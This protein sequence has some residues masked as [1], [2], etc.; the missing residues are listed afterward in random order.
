MAAGPEN[1][2]P[3][4]IVVPSGYEDPSGLVPRPAYYVE[5]TPIPDRVLVDPKTAPE[6]VDELIEAKVQ[7]LFQAIYD[8][9]DS[10]IAASYGL[11][12]ARIDADEARLM[13]FIDLVDEY[14][15]L[16]NS[17]ARKVKEYERQA[18]R[19]RK[20]RRR[21]K[22][23]PVVGSSGESEETPRQKAIRLR[24][25]HARRVEEARQIQNLI[26]DRAILDLFSVTDN[27]S[28]SGI[29]IVLHQLDQSIE[30]LMKAMVG[31]QDVR[32]EHLK[33]R[34]PVDYFFTS[35]ARRL[36][37]VGED[38]IVLFQRYSYKSSPE[39]VREAADCEVLATTLEYALKGDTISEDRETRRHLRAIG[40]AYFTFLGRRA[41]YLSKGG[42]EDTYPLLTLMYDQIIAA[43]YRGNPE[44]SR[45][46]TDHLNRYFRSLATAKVVG[47]EVKALSDRIKNQYFDLIT[48]GIVD[49][50]DTFSPEDLDDSRREVEIRAVEVPDELFSY[51]ESE[52]MTIVYG[53]LSRY[54]FGRLSSRD[55]LAMRQCKP[56]P[57]LVAAML[58]LELGVASKRD[59][60][61][62]MLV[63]NVKAQAVRT[64]GAGQIK[65]YAL[66]GDIAEFAQKNIEN[67]S[68]ADLAEFGY[69]NVEDESWGEETARR[70]AAFYDE[71]KTLGDSELTTA[72]FLI[73]GSRVLQERLDPR[74]RVQAENAYLAAEILDNQEWFV[75]P[76]GDRFRSVGDKEMADYLIDAMTFRMDSSYPREY[77]IQVKFAGIE[78]P[79]EF[80]F[81]I[82][83]NLLGPSRQ[84]LI[85]DCVLRA[86]FL[87]IVLKRLY[88]ITSGILSK[89]GGE[90]QDEAA[91]GSD[92]PEIYRRAHWRHLR[93]TPARPITLE[94]HSAQK[95]AREVREDYGIDIFAEI[96][97]RRS[98]GTLLPDEFI[99]YVRESRPSRE[100]DPLVPN[101]L[102]YVPE[103]MT[104]P[105]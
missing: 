39:P 13:A 86:Q 67:L 57:A 20:R 54:S 15:L 69:L 98:V 65:A 8:E 1:F 63:Y 29:P 16:E 41:L 14:R 43:H 70:L 24:D 56:G 101:D 87:N 78:K 74:D 3:R 103:L 73:Y 32:F 6:L 100:A 55:Y 18:G 79:F 22:E 68:D 59:L 83:K 84:P 105:L 64:R 35:L 99:T 33:E 25:E 71:N 30:G 9:D 40:T 23:L 76:R 80:W 60:L 58:S 53:I 7:S 11:E 27:H 45:G 28:Y 12:G 36:A 97:R 96:K 90:P 102:V 51:L 85:A 77:M 31:N 37:S 48:K 50:E 38:D 21:T 17:H 75:S 52:E 89:P 92:Q 26:L 104:L 4:R 81:D 42:A 44:I 93:S 82:H 94:T 10:Y 5:V 61:D 91:A 62:F 49:P 46:I 88:F 2:N 47:P 95:H 72:F 66:F 34:N 19:P